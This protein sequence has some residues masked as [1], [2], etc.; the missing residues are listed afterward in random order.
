MQRTAI[1]VRKSDEIT[2]TIFRLNT[3]LLESIHYGGRVSLHMKKNK[4]CAKEAQSE[5]GVHSPQPTNLENIGH[6]VGMSVSGYRG[7]RFEP[8]INMFF[9]WARHFIRIVS[10]DSAVKWVPDG[11]NLVKN[12]QC[13]E[14]FG[15]I[16]LK[17]HVFFH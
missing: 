2:K 11:N 5:K 17:N 12:V 1:R 16:A 4:P 7:W 8:R 14:I 9:P 15:G 13:Y 10:V 6:V 3:S